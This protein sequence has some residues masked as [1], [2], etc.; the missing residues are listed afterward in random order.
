MASIS[1]KDTDGDSIVFLL[2]GCYIDYYVNG[3]MK[4]S[5]LTS[6]HADGL[7]LHLDGTSAGS[8]ASCRRTTLPAGQETNVRSVVALFKATQARSIFGFADSDRDKIVFKLVGGFLDY[9]VNGCVKV[10]RLTDLRANGCT[11]FLNGTSAGLWESSRM[12]VV[13]EHLAT[14]IDHIFT[15]FEKSSKHRDLDASVVCCQCGPAIA[16]APEVDCAIDDSRHKDT[17]R[18]LAIAMLNAGRAVLEVAKTHGASPNASTCK[19]LVQQFFSTSDANHLDVLLRQWMVLT[20]Q[21]QSNLGTDSAIEMAP[22]GKFEPDWV[23]YTYRNEAPGKRTFYACPLFFAGTELDNATTYLHETTHFCLGTDDAGG[24]KF[25]ECVNLSY[26]MAVKNAQN[27]MYFS[28]WAFCSFCQGKLAEIYPERSS[29]KG[30]RFNTPQMQMQHVRGALSTSPEWSYCISGDK[31][32]CKVT[33]GPKHFYHSLQQSWRVENSNGTAVQLTD[34]NSR[35]LSVEDSTSGLMVCDSVN[36]YHIIMLSRDLGFGAV[37]CGGE[38]GR[39]FIFL[40]RGKHRAEN[41]H[42]EEW[43]EKWRQEARTAPAVPQQRF[44]SD[45]TQPQTCVTQ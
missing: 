40:R 23:A 39:S 43:T 29:K 6:L 37:H 18:V 19:T 3:R 32:G 8:W 36:T 9:Y 10:S 15:L 26:D 25:D 34:P 5:N 30:M 24:Y 42:M 21:L 27:Y 28:L 44:K 1:F 16:L 7:T 45:V 14:S 13:P 38:G 2:D 33:D 12:T 17:P 41:L 22:D 20:D 35:K 11:L 4:V 31:V